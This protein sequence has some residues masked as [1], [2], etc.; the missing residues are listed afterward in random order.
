MLRWL[1][2][3][4]EAVWN[5]GNLITHT[6][7]ETEAVAVVDTGQAGDRVVHGLERAGCFG[8]RRH[9]LCRRR[10]RLR[11]SGSGRR[12]RRRRRCCWRRALSQGKRGDQSDAGARRETEKQ[13]VH[14]VLLEVR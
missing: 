9:S 7:G 11:R 2:L 10:Y 1:P 14:N 8:W 4:D 13:L 3:L 12:R 6:D 5:D